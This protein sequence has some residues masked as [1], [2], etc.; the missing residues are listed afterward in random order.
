M[1]IRLA[2]GVATIIV[3][4][5][6]LALCERD[7]NSQVNICVT[8]EQ[9]NHIRDVM[10]K[11][12]DGALDDQVSHLFSTWVKDPTGQ[13]KRAQNGL[14]TTLKAYLLSRANVLAWNPSECTAGMQLQSVSAT[15]VKPWR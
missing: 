15:S 2:V 3:T 14:N 1:I 13:P 8:P 5:I 4:L 10:L 6:L 11:S 7:A 9:R 12:V